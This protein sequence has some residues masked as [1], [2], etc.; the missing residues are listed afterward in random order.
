MDASA[1]AVD[2]FDSML[3]QSIVGAGFNRLIIKLPHTFALDDCKKFPE[4]HCMDNAAVDTPVIAESV[5]FIGSR[6]S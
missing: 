5:K 1:T 4:L 6:I 3:A 2:E